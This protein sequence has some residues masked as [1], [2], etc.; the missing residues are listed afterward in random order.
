MQVYESAVKQEEEPLGDIPVRIEIDVRSLSSFVQSKPDTLEKMWDEA[1]NDNTNEDGILQGDELNNFLHDVLKK[2]YEF[3]SPR[4]ESK[5][6]KA[7]TRS[8]VGEFKQLIS[9]SCGGSSQ[10]DVETMVLSRKQLMQFNGQMKEKSFDRE[11]VSVM[12]AFDTLAGKVFEPSDSGSVIP[13]AKGGVE[14]LYQNF[15][16]HLMET[17]IQKYRRLKSEIDTF[18]D[19]LRELADKKRGIEQYAWYGFCV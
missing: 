7:Q 19:S 2:W 10:L 14:I 1:Q 11:D 6:V 12:T 17:P 18:K 3:Y 15:K 16:N 4:E 13:G 8:A 5:L 9:S